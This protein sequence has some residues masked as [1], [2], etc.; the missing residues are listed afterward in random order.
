[1]TSKNEEERLHWAN[2]V[3][4]EQFRLLMGGYEP[5][6]SKDYLNL[7]KKSLLII[8]RILT[9]HCQLNYYL[10]KLWI[11]TDTACSAPS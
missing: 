10:R 1:M 3:G 2:P 9:G 4:M 7:T 6:H 11:S 8:G 5:K